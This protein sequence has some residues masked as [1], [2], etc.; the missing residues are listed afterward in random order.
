MLGLASRAWAQASLAG[1]AAQ[2]LRKL[3]AA[4]RRARRRLAD[5]ASSR[6]SAPPSRPS[7]RS[8]PPC[9]DRVPI[10]FDYRTARPASSTER[11]VQPWALASLAR[12]LVPHRLRRRP[13]RDRASSGSAGSR[14]PSSA[15]RQ[16]RVV[17]RARRPRAR[18]AMI[19]ASSAER[20]PAPPSCGCAPARGHTLR[21]RARSASARSTSDWS[22]A[23]GA[24]RRR[25]RRSPT[26]SPARRRRAGRGSRSTLRRGR[27]S[28]GRA[29]P[30]RRRIR[31]R[32][33]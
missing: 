28:A 13:R 11:H 19:S 8:R 15:A 31:R 1:P 7:S 29:A 2:A 20:R 16:G 5:R 26:R 30:L 10:R 25:P 21:R 4:G 18:G 14:A 6:G 9:V 3:K 22:R 24:L 33:A 17:R 27:R 12:P 23:R 32:A